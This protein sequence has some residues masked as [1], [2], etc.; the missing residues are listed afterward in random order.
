M[1][2]AWTLHSKFQ[3]QKTEIIQK[4][5]QFQFSNFDQ[6]HPSNFDFSS[7]QNWEVR[8]EMGK[9]IEKRGAC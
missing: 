6:Q 5:N 3:H 7:S 1:F 4:R 8:R 2:H 9:L